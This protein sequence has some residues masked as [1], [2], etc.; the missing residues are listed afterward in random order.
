MEAAH[1]RGLYVILDIVI[2]HSARV[3]DYLSNGN[4][5]IEFKDANV[6]YLIARFD[7]DGFRMDTVKYIEPDIIEMFGNALREFAFSIGKQNFFTFGEIYD[8]EQT[9]NKFVGRHSENIEGFGVDA[10]LDFPLFYKLPGVAKANIDVAEIRNV[11]RDRKNAERELLSSHGEAGKYFIS[12]LDNHDQKERFN[13]PNTPKEQVLLGLAVLFCLQGIPCLYYG[14]EQGLNGTKNPSGDL[15]LGDNQEAV[16][17]ALWGKVPKAFDDQNF[18]YLHLQLLSKL[19]NS[20]PALK[21]GRLYFREVA[22]NGKDFGHSTGRGGIIAFSRVLSGREI[23][24]IANTNAHTS[25]P[26]F[27][28]FVIMDLDI[29]RS[30]PFIKVAYSNMGTTGQEKAQLLEDARFFTDTVTIAETAAMH[31]KLRPMEVQ[32]LI[33]V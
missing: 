24:V 11:F 27:D 33:P 20:E 14:T 26:P 7:V 5:R 29:N 25:D 21:F 23:V 6:M 2:N 16:R 32:V 3:F 18:F 12:F 4:T 31:V 1:A 19:G 9:I 28:G 8:D 15:Q 30:E 22:G 17:E 13:H 10:A